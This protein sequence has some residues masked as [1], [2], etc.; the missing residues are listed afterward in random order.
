MIKVD[1]NLDRISGDDTMNMKPFFKKAWKILGH[2]IAIGL[3][4]TLVASCNADA[5]EMNDAMIPISESSRP[6][7]V[8]SFARYASETRMAIKYSNAAC[9]Q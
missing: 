1:N 2:V 5:A 4:L 6:M 8:R 7:W 3:A 9:I